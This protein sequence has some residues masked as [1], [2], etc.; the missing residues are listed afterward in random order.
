MLTFFNVLV[1]WDINYIFSFSF[2]RILGIQGGNR[3][4]RENSGLAL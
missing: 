2:A 4:G 3:W 1:F